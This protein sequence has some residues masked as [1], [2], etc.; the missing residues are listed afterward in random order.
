MVEKVAQSVESVKRNAVRNLVNRPFS[1]TRQYWLLLL[2][3]SLATAMIAY[4]SGWFAQEKLWRATL[5]GQSM[6]TILKDDRETQAPTPALQLLSKE[7]SPEKIRFQPSNQSEQT[8]FNIIGIPTQVFAPAFLLSTGTIIMLLLAGATY[9]IKRAERKAQE[10]EAVNQAL[11]Q[12]I[13]ERLNSQEELFNSQQQC[14]SLVNWIEGIVWEVDLQRSQ[15]TFVSQKAEKLSGYPVKT[16]LSEPNFWENHLH[17]DDREW[18][19]HYCRQCQQ[20]QTEYELEYRMMATKS[21]VIWVRDLVN[22]LIENNRPVKLQGLTIEVTQYKQAESKRQQSELALRES[23]ERWQLALRGNNDGIWDWNVRTNQVFFSSRWKEMLGYTDAEI[24]NHLE[25]WQKRIHPEDRQSVDYLIQEHFAKETPF[26]ISEHRLLCKDGTYRWILDRGQALWDEKGEVIRMAGSH[27][28]IT[29]RKRTEN[30]LRESQR[31]TQRIADAIPNILYLYDLIE[32]RNIY[33]NHEFEIVLG[34]SPT[35]IQ[36]MEQLFLTRLIH[37][38]DFEQYTQLVQ[39]LNLAK[40]GDMIE[41]EYR[42]QH[43][44]GEWRWLQAWETV[45]T[46]NAAGCPQQIL[47]TA[48]D[49]TERKQAEVKLQ[50]ANEQLIIKVKELE[51]RNNEIT[52]LSEMSDLLQTCLSWE[53]VS[54]VIAQFAPLLFPNNSGAVFAISN[55]RNLVE[56]LS[57]WGGLVTSNVLFSTTECL[58]LRRGQPHLVEDTSNGLVCKHL[59]LCSLPHAYFCIP[60]VAQGETMGVLYLSFA[61]KADL[62]KAKQHLAVTVARQISLSMANLKLHET[63]QQQRIR[64]SLTGL[65]NRRYLEESLE[66]ELHRARQT[67]QFLGV[68][69]IDVDHFKHF[70]DTFGH[71]AGDAVLREL[72]V[73]LTTNLRGSDIACRYGGEELTVIFPEAN[74]EETRLRAEYLREG[75]KH[76]RIEHRRQILGAITISLGVA[77]FPQHGSTGEAIIRVA[78]TA[79]YRAKREGRNRV[80]VAP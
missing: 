27:T 62:T 75:V 61:N 55:S 39:Q 66:R 78:D 38:E 51:L 73:F 7:V 60:M 56:A 13:R 36:Q 64:D 50:Q 52:L 12:E 77:C 18:V 2:G 47:G 10:L 79:L 9:C 1:A 24:T 20:E 63:L 11:Q 71:E 49:I 58:A 37:P 44:N 3:V 76:L 25:E 54:T 6:L 34:Y 17:P 45:F 21:R 42:M 57:S 35:E 43:V 22:V 72:G 67:Q 5:S 26:Y 19:I 29:E 69:M 14:H 15:F 59:K 23:E 32:Q 48:Q 41:G 4:R 30:A 28:D 65:Y 53:E 70:N 40:D 33:A 16:W 31:L 8:N 74:L 80:V 46:R 68:C